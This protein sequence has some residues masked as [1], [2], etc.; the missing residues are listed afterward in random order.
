MTDIINKA[1]NS[2]KLL[3]LP[4]RSCNWILISQFSRVK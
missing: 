2:R 3:I 4:E 1:E